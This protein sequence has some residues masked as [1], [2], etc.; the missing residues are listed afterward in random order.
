MENKQGMK[1]K[2]ATNN[3]RIDQSSS[4]IPTLLIEFAKGNADFITERVL[5]SASGWNTDDCIVGIDFLIDRHNKLQKKK[6][7]K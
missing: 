5:L 2:K 1:K 7:D 4:E 3:Y 6:V